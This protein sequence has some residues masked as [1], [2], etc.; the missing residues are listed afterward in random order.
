MMNK[1]NYREQYL[2]GGYKYEQ[3]KQQNDEWREPPARQFITPI[4]ATAKAPQYKGYIGLI[5]IGLSF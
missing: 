4:R 1:G 3:T 2:P 5:S